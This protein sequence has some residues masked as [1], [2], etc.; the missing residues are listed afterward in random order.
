MVVGYQDFRFAQ[1]GHLIR[2]QNIPLAVVVVGIVGEQDT[3]AVADSNAG[4][5][6]EE[7]IGEAVILGVSE[8]VECVPG[9]DHSHD[10]GLAAASGH[11]EGSAEQAGI[12]VFVRLSD[13]VVNPV[14]ASTTSDFRDV[15][16]RFERLDLAEE[17]LALAVGLGPI[18]QQPAG[19]LGNV[20]V[21]ALTPAADTFADA[22]DEG[23]LFDAV[24]GP[25]G[26][27]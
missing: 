25:L 24:L 26:V 8:L 5:D 17:E 1:L 4:C 15:Y 20:L 12:G 2:G 21:A 9:D 27:E 16:C 6:N 22:V 3:K 23:V 19:S 7:R 14:V 13:L 11:L 18:L 10:Y